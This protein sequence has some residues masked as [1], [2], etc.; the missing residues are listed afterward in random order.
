MSGPSK[1]NQVSSSGPGGYAMAWS[2]GPGDAF[3]QTQQATGEAAS[4]HVVQSLA[5]QDA[6]DLVWQQQAGG[7]AQVVSAE[8]LPLGASHRVALPGGMSTS[9]ATSAPG[10]VAAPT[11]RITANEEA[12]LLENEVLPRGLE[13][14]A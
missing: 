2:S 6:R 11:G 7:P 4:G 8:Q 12:P 13:R 9:A 3:L 5:G 14:R 10:G 1:F